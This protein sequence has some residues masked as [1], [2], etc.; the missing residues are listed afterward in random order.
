[1]STDKKETAPEAQ[2]EILEEPAAEAEAVSEEA[3]A[4]E[5]A[6]SP[7]APKADKKSRREEKKAAKK[8]DEEKLA[9]LENE[10]AALN[11]KYLR[12]CAEYD[13]FR[14]RSQKEKEGLYGDI[15]ADTVQKFLPVY[16]N[17]ERALRQGTEDEAYRKGV[18]MIM[19]QFEST[20]EKLGVT[21]I[22]CLGEKFDPELHNAVMHVDDEEKGENEIVEVFQ[23][24]FKLGDKVIRFAMVKVAN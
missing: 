23:K 3:A 18:E 17:L 4:P 22:E 20:L 13:N 2:D 16:D 11:D 19:T 21:A 5:T 12:I 7:E 24:G 6:E 1:M 9:A 14:R 15:K 10:N 8:K